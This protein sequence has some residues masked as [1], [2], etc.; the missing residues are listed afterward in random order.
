M[1]KYLLGRLIEPSTWVGIGVILGA[2]FFP[3]WFIIL[4]GVLLIVSGD[5]WLKNW[6]ARNAPGISA[7]VD[8]WTR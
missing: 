8:E 5:T 6:V 2:L 3:R 1:K 4:L 7:K